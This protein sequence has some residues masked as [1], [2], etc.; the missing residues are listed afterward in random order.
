M[1]RL[2]VPNDP[3]GLKP[4]RPGAQ[5]PFQVPPPHVHWPDRISAIG[6]LLSAGIAGIAVAKDSPP[7][8]VV[9]LVTLVSTTAYS[10]IANTI[11]QIRA[12]RRAREAAQAQER[13]QTE[14]L[15]RVTTALNS[16]LMLVSTQLASRQNYSNAIH[17]AIQQLTNNLPVD[18]PL[19]S[20]AHLRRGTV[21]TYGQIIDDLPTE[22]E[23]S[24]A[25]TMGRLLDSI[26]HRLID[27]L[28]KYIE[29]CERAADQL[30]GWERE[31]TYNEAE[32]L[33]LRTN[34]FLQ[35]YSIFAEQTITSDFQLLK[36]FGIEQHLRARVRLPPP[37]V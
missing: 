34:E 30:Q 24:Q 33:R 5:L 7:G 15:E 4:Y 9:L 25:R 16:A 27:S 35:K 14:A 29:T 37:K 20:E 31:H 36:P 21:S 2:L 11:R 17:G 12:R 6:S 28:P 13:A 26:V 23:P 22:V 19:S 10:P 18:S 32:M 1:R 8:L 3:F